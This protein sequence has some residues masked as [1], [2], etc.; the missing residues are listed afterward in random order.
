MKYLFQFILVFIVC[1]GVY[2]QKHNKSDYM[3]IIDDSTFVAATPE[4]GATLKGIYKM[5][6]LEKIETWFGF[7]FGEVRR[8]Y[9]YWNDT[10][11]MVTESQKLYSAKEENKINP[12]TIKAS[13]TGRYLFKGG[14]LTD[15]SQK[16]N[17]SISDTAADKKEVEATFFSLSEKYVSLLNEKR[18]KKKNRLPLGDHHIE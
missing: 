18:Q 16:G 11:I 7:N 1:N 9:F 17:Y 12:D 15:I 4:R 8:D 10:L 5:N 6:S 2:A 13:Y 3:I 14:R